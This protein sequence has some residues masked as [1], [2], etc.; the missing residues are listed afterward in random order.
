MG[1][2]RVGYECVGWCRVVWGGAG[3]CRVVWGGVTGWCRPYTVGVSRVSLTTTWVVK[4]QLKA[5]GRMT[6][7]DHTL[8]I[9]SSVGWKRN[10]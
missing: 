8:R 5:E 2:F 9:T 1:W 10:F 6:G 7:L 4:G 3:W